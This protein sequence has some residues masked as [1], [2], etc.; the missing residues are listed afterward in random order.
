MGWPCRR[1]MDVQRLGNKRVAERSKGERY[2]VQKVK[3]RAFYT[4][5]IAPYGG[6]HKVGSPRTISINDAAQASHKL[7][8]Q[9]WLTN[10]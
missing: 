6:R 3:N 2:L 8:D 1:Y 4:V 7:I 9:V 5:L 10:Y